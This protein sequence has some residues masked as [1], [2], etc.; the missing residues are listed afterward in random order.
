MR[1]S[2]ADYA[3]RSTCLIQPG[4]YEIAAL[5]GLFFVHGKIAFQAQR[6]L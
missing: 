4:V 2:L 5:R 3:T 6:S 1:S